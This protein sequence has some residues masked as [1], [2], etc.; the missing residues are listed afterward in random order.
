MKH[1]FKRDLAKN[2]VTKRR[3]DTSVTVGDYTIQKYGD[4][5][6]LG[7]KTGYKPGPH[8]KGKGRLEQ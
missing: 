4:T 3:P 6:T 8:Y 5:Y 2:P 1:S 7:H